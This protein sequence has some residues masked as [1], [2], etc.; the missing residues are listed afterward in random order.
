MEFLSGGYYKATIHRVIQPPADQRGYVRLGIFYFAYPDDD[1]KLLPQTQSP[2]LLREGIKRRFDDSQAPTAGEWR[3][4]RTS[5]YG[6]VELKKGEEKN[7][8]E[9]FVNGVL[10][11]HYN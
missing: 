7:V 11:K 3:R 4:G 2:V 6:H 8:E 9:E 10:V 1:V 5:A